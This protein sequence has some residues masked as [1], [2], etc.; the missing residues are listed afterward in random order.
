MVAAVAAV[1]IA[2][3]RYA[4]RHPAF[5]AWWFMVLTAA[6]AALAVTDALQRRLGW[7]VWMAF[8]TVI[9]GSCWNDCRRSRETRHDR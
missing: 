5:G 8:C 3:G 9:N 2:G 1:S 7:A 4:D 6:C